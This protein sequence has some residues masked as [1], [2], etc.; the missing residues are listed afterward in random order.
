MVVCTVPPI[1]RHARNKV[2]WRRVLEYNSEVRRWCRKLKI[3]YLDVFEHF[4]TR[5]SKGKARMKI[6]TVFYQ[7]TYH[8]GGK[9]LIHLNWKGLNELR[10]F[11]D[12]KDVLQ[13]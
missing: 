10:R 1:P 3:E 2:V 5:D 4:I 11:I 8:H 6:R 9:D 12:K 7:R 13:K